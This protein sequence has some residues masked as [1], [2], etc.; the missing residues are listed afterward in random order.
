MKYSELYKLLKK[1][2]HYDDDKLSPLDTL[3]V[4]NYTFHS[5]SY[6]IIPGEDE[7]RCSVH[8]FSVK[9]PDENSWKSDYTIL[10]VIDSHVKENAEFRFHIFTP[11]DSQPARDVILL[12]HGFNEKNWIKY[13]PWAYNLMMA[14]GKT[15]V[16]FPMTFHM[17][18]ALPEWSNP[19]L[20]TELYNARKQE[21]P[22]IIGSS[23]VNV[24]ISTRINVK[25]QRFIWSG[26]LT[27]YDVIQFVEE[28]K[29][30]KYACIAPD[31]RFDFFAYSIG[32]LLAQTLMLTNKNDYF[33]DSKMALFCSGSVFSR[34]TPVCKVIMDSETEQMLY[35]YII[36]YLDTFRAKDHW[37]GHFLSE[38]HPEG[39]N[40]LS[41][42]NYNKL[43]D[44]REQLF[45]KAHDR[46]YAIALKQDYIIP[47]YEVINTLQGRM[48]DI[49]VKVDVDDF[50]YPYKHEDPFPLKESISDAVELAFQTTF[51]KLSDFLK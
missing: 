22:D 2:V 25:P 14:T 16:L 9:A 17:N 49:P 27:Y 51:K 41:L 10:D 30:G 40:F 44:Y 38:Q 3:D 11:K 15:V 24:A 13:Y 4:Y 42:L 8:D 39:Y 45:T 36:G 20:M 19:R 6:H 33:H 26:M 12:L 31:A 32:G 50:P 46:I 29:Q 28:V 5:N 21:F 48:R 37:L 7:Y 35:R 1:S 43:M 18:R 34:L 23:F 47:Y